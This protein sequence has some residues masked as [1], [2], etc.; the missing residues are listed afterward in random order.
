MPPRLA[1]SSRPSPSGHCVQLCLGGGTRVGA[2]GPFRSRA[3]PREPRN[4]RA[5]LQELRRG[6]GGFGRMSR[7]EK[8]S[9]VGIFS[10]QALIRRGPLQLLRLAI[11]VHLCVLLMNLG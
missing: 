2:G 6:A 1:A 9:P 7:R 11:I 4:P 8:Q 10:I 5:K 3:V